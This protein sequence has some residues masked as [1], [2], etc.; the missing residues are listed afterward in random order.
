MSEGP[1]SEHSVKLL[2]EQDAP[3]QAKNLRQVQR[4]KG[5]KARD[6]LVEAYM[7]WCRSMKTPSIQ[8]SV[9]ISRHVELPPPYLPSVAP[10]EEL[11]KLY[12]EGLQPESHHRGSYSLLRAI[13]PSIRMASTITIL[14]DENNDVVTSQFCQHEED[15]HLAAGSIPEGSACIIKEPW[16]ILST[17]GSYV[18]RV[19]HVNDVVWLP[20]ADSRMPSAWQ[21]QKIDTVKTAKQ[22]KADGNESLKMGKPHEAVER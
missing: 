16:L 13:T 21:S 15:I 18:V 10:F 14:E 2:E 8:G 6:D 11:K 5:K 12:I 3:D 22:W 9:Y 7:M 19:D 4:S 20:K 1:R 17:D